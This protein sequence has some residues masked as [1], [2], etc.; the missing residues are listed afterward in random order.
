MVGLRYGSCKS[1][2][3]A[4]HA[5]GQAQAFHPAVKIDLQTGLIAIAGRKNDA[6]LFGINLKNRSDRGV[7]F[8]VQQHDVLAMFE[9]FEGYASAELDRSGDIDQHIHFR[10]PRQQES[11]IGDDRL[12]FAHREFELRSG[13]AATTTSFTPAYSQRSNARCTRR[14]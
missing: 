10:R 11:V 8:G 12:A 6:M 13:V 9:G 1:F 2:D 14:L 5:R 3:V 7:D 4:D